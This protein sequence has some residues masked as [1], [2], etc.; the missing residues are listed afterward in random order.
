[1]SSSKFIRL[2]QN[3]GNSCGSL[4][5]FQMSGGLFSRSF[6]NENKLDPTLSSSHRGCVGSTASSWSWLQYLP[7]IL[8]RERERRAVA[9]P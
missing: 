6:Q 7:W 1:M 3:A 4:K 2:I 8:Q 5:S 9:N